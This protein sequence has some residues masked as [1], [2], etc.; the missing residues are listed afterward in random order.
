[1]L[2]DG[3]QANGVT[4]AGAVRADSGLR[5]GQAFSVQVQSALGKTFIQL[6]ATRIPLAE[7]PQMTHGMLVRAEVFG[8]GNAMQVRITPQTPQ[9]TANTAPQ[10]AQGLL[11]EVL[12][13]L[14]AMNAA[15]SAPL[16]LPAQLPQSA[17]AMQQLF[18]LFLSRGVMGD[19]LNS[20]ANL[21]SQAAAARALPPD[22][23]AHFAALAAQLNVSESGEFRKLLERLTGERNTEARIAAIMND[24]ENRDAAIAALR[25]SLQQ[26]IL[27][28]REMKPLHAWLRATGHAREFNQAVDRLTERLAGAALQQLHGADQPYVFIDAPLA[29]ASGFLH[30]QIHLFGEG[31]GKCR[32]IGPH[33]ATI[34]ID[35][36]M[37]R[38]GALWITIQAKKER[39]LCEIRAASDILPLFEARREELTQALRR[40]GFDAAHVNTTPWDGNR[41]RAAAAMLRRFSGIDI[42][43]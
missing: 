23:A 16:L 28:L 33:N 42:S 1:M 15:D 27:R 24:A 40:A 38:L 36:A 12:T 22:T 17:E 30:A 31:G 8:S 14:N 39:C 9:P 2:T 25:E 7:H 6:G 18:S 20:L 35:L 37:S 34:V 19:N 11:A 21:L 41:I 5:P 13:A 10:V 32:R 29:P 3:I 43:A 4:L 26:Q